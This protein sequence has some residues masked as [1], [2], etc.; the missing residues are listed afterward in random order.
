MK[1]L[2]IILATLFIIPISAQEKRISSRIKSVVVYLDGAQVERSK[3]VDLP[4]G[5]TNIIFTGLSS[6]LETSSIQAQTGDQV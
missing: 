1:I 5:T 3:K 6:K 2:P 4:A